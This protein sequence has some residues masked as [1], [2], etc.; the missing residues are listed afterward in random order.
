L[1]TGCCGGYS[2]VRGTKLNGHGEKCRLESFIIF[3]LPK[4]SREY[5]RECGMHMEDMFL[6]LVI[7]KVEYGVIILK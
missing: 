7:Q 2:S 1:K 3:I 5:W 4:M 6:K